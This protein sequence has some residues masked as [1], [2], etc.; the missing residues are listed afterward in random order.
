[1]YKA[2]QYPVVLPKGFY[3]AVKVEVLNEVIQDLSDEISTEWSHR[4]II[5][6]FNVL[7]R[8]VNQTYKNYCGMSTFSFSVKGF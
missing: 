5:S 2:L 7:T 8:N 3:G 6:V 4:N 1:M